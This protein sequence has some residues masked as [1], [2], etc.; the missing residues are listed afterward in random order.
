MKL[1]SQNQKMKR[2]SGGRFKKI[3]NFT[4]PAFQTKDGFRTCPMAGVCASGCYARMGAYVWP[5]VY[6]K[7]RANLEATFENGFV[8]SAVA[9]LTRAKPDLVR[10]HDSGDFYSESYLTDWFA[11]ARLMPDTQFY[12]YTKMVSLVKRLA[13]ALPENLTVIFSLGGKQDALINQGTDRHSRVFS[14]LAELKRAGYV[15]TSHDDTKAIGRNPK[16][17]LVYH[18]NKG[19]DKTQWIRCV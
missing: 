2:S 5:K 3:V 19:F 17:G 9:E 1:F 12:A 8:E 10:I 7:H 18:G 6:A 11:I 16:I 4:L 15:D 13:W 14:S